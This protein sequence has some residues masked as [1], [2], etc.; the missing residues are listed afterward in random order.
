MRL[1]N[2]TT[3]SMERLPIDA[4]LDITPVVGYADD[5]GV[6]VAALAV[7]AAHIKPEH[8]EK[9][10]AKLRE[11]FGGNDNADEAESSPA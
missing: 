3:Q 8:T 10:L 1:A 9:A 2:K 6:I 4:I 7:V 5:L 11:W